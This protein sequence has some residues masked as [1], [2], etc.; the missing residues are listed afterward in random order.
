MDRPEVGTAPELC[1][2]CSLQTDL[3]EVPYFP[4]REKILLGS[5]AKRGLGFWHDRVFAAR[6]RNSGSV[7]DLFCIATNRVVELGTRV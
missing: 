5:A 6:A 3:L 1:G 2:P 4:A 7:T